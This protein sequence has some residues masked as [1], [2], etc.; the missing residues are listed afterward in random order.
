MRT[1]E[2]IREA[3]KFLQNCKNCRL[4]CKKNARFWFYTGIIEITERGSEDEYIRA[5]SCREDLW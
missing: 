2:K 3:L 5:A 1:Y 4:F